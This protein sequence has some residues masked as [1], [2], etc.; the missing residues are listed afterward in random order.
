MSIRYSDNEDS[1]SSAVGDIILFFSLSNIRL[2]LTVFTLNSVLFL[3]SLE[4]LS[5]R[6]CTAKI[7]EATYVSPTLRD[8][9][10]ELFKTL[11]KLD[12]ISVFSLRLEI[13]GSELISSIHSTLSLSRLSLDA[14]NNFLPRHLVSRI[15]NSTCAL[16]IC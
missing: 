8:S 4:Y 12:V 1:L 14:S 13:T 3:L 7:S 6:I 10:S 11:Y 2:A 15:D 16:S 9:L 5:S